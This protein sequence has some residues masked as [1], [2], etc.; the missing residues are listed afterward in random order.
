MKIFGCKTVA[1]IAALGAVTL[2]A[3]DDL[4]YP[5]GDYRDECS[6]CHRPDAWTPA[7]IGPGFDHAQF[8]FRLDGAHRTVTCRGC[9]ATLE[10]S[11]ASSSCVDC[12]QDVHRGELGI[13][14]ARCH[15][16]RNFIE[17]VELVRSHRG[18]RFPLTGAHTTLDCEACH[19]RGGG[20]ALR[21]VNTPIE[22]E[23]CHIA[24]FRAAK[25]PDHVGGGFPTDC[26]RCHTTI[27]WDSARFDHAATG[28]PLTG[29]HRSVSC[30]ECH[31]NAPPGQASPQCV[32]CHLGDYTGV[33]N[34]RHVGSFPTE[35][36]SCH[37]TTRWSPASFDHG[38][39]DFPLTGAH[40]NTSC[41]A[42]HADGVYDGKRTDCFSCHAADYDSANN[43]DHR[44][45]GFPTD[46]T[47]CHNTNS[48][49]GAE[50]DHS[51]TDFPLTGAHRNTSCN[52]CHGDGV[53]DGKPTDCY[54]CHASDYNQTSDPNHRGAGFPTDC[55]LCHTT[56]SW[57]NARFDH[58]GQYFPIYSGKHRGEWDRC[59]DC[60][61]NPNNYREFTCLTCHR[62]GETDRDH[63]EVNGYRYDSQACYQCHP[64]GRAED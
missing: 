61:T 2:A 11:R 51:R 17:R 15:T 47:Q 60:H 63:D 31:G 5:H 43:P 4:P 25:S 12:H 10:F 14:C 50:F 16:T 62:R 42:C 39:T 27:A 64:D 35:C 8:G 3:A 23:A 55:A 56:S 22:C 9:H 44:R 53:Y 19:P 36:S 37:T 21:F 28:F 26:T 20:D 30:Q 29:A 41:N 49:D 32:A 54:S 1:W 58:D 13:D 59:S 24:Q 48:W 46:C 40:R 18:T 57:D 7:S 6:K 52:A 34:P 38:A 45:S 33:T